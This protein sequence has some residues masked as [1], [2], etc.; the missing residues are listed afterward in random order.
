MKL[1]NAA[2]I[3]LGIFA[4]LRF[5]LLSVA[6]NAWGPK[7]AKPTHGIHVENALSRR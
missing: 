2:L 4:I 3:A 5:P 7:T 1:L 6:K